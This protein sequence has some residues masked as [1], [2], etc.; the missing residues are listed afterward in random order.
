[1]DQSA[2]GVAGVRGM[3]YARLE[4]PAIPAWVDLIANRFNSDMA[5]E[6]YAML[7]FSPAMREWVGGR[8]AK[9]FRDNGFTI[10]N[11][12]FESTIE[13]RARD[14]R[15][16]KTGQIMAR[17]NEHA[18][19]ADQHWASL[20][21]TLILNGQTTVCYDGQYFF[22]TDH[23]EGNSGT[24]SNSISVDISTLPATLHGSTTA[25]SI[26][27][28]Q[29]AIVSGITQI[30]TFK[31]D[32]GEPMNENANSF[33]VLV[34]PSLS[35]VAGNAIAPAALGALAQNL[36][37]AI[38]AGNS[39]QVQSSVRLGAWTDKFAVFRTDSAIKPFILQEETPVDVKVWDENSDH[40]KDND[41]YK[42]GLDAWRNGGN[43]YWQRACLVTLT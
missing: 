38:K 6:T 12:H 16:D 13:I 40:F 19:R 31:D 22:D 9:G 10:V 11:K 36:N 35:I 18:D 17:V 42:F 1:M 15:R 21:A 4:Q 27:E 20:L 28:M 33:L 29:Q 39:L 3:Y 30:G 43:G 37:P 32:Q 34:P 7:G 8:Q 41:S 24:Q 2:L 25:P 26:E 23:S 5:S 14:M